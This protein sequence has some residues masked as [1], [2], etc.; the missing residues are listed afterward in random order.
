MTK[1]IEST[2][3]IMPIAQR[4][5]EAVRAIE[6]RLDHLGHV[7]LMLGKHASARLV[8]EAR[9]ALKTEVLP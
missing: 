9:K 6:L 3:H 2:G 5:A 4:E 1:P 7:L 8:E